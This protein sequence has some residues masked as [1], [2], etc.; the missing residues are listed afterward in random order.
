MSRTKN[1]APTVKDVARLAKVATGTVSRVVNND[2]T[3]HPV[4]REAVSAAIRELDYRPSPIARTLRTG[5]TSIIGFVLSDLTNPTYGTS[6]PVAQELLRDAGYTLIVADSQMD[7][8]IELKNLAQLAGLRV[9]GIIWTPIASSVSPEVQRVVSKTPVVTA[10]GGGIHR[11]AQAH[12]NVD[13]DPATFE[14]AQQ[15]AD[16]GHRR[17]GLITLRGLYPDARVSTFLPRLNERLAQSG[18]VL[19]TDSSWTFDRREQ[20]YER[21]PALLRDPG[22]PTAVLVASA[23][24]P[25]VLFSAREAGLVI[26]RDLSVVCIGDSELARVYNPPLDA[27]QYGYAEAAELAI[28]L[29]L[30]ILA[31]EEVAEKSAGLKAVYERRGSVAPPPSASPK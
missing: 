28:R 20:A 7:P 30:A 10:P 25:A 21:L 9:D 17:I 14:A 5:K 26:P 29:M 16:A 15:L 18:S 2:P 8:E 24:L 27:V 3:V 4:I 6:V 31:G 12:V 1:A 19:A 23:L 11:G 13:T 22:R